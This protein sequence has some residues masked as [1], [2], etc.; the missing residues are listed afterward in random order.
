MCGVCRS[1]F[2][3]GVVGG[4]DTLYQIRFQEEWPDFCIWVEGLWIRFLRNKKVGGTD[5]GNVGRLILQNWSYFTDT[6]Y[7]LQFPIHAHHVPTSLSPP[8]VIAT[9]PSS[10]LRLNS[11]PVEQSYRGLLTRMD[12]IDARRA[13]GLEES[14]SSL[15]RQRFTSL[16]R[17]DQILGSLVEAHAYPEES[18]QIAGTEETDVSGG[19]GRKEGGRRRAG[20]DCLCISICLPI[21]TRS[22]RFCRSFLYFRCTPLRLTNTCSCCYRML[23]V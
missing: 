17:D 22:Q 19:E 6:S 12:S 1:G 10:P 11:V 21:L 20:S 4:G 18:L 15:S 13:A 14:I 23:R 5:S 16:H 9:P 7:S 3:G 2:G 8:T